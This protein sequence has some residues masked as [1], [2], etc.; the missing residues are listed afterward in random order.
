GAVRLALQQLTDEQQQVL[1]LRF[2]QGRSVADTAELL[3]KSVT[4]VKQLQ[5]RAVAAL[6]RQLGEW[7]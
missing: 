6:R 3:N 4:A 2:E 1:A 7:Q 5:F